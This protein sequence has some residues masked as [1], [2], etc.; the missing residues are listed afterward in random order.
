MKNI[1]ILSG[2]LF[3]SFEIVGFDPIEIQIDVDGDQKSESV[4]GQGMQFREDRIGDEVIEESGKHE[5]KD[6]ESDRGVDDA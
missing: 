2:C 3:L 5:A 4:P 1:L 6:K